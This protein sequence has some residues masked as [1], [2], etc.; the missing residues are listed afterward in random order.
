MWRCAQRDY[1][2]LVH[3]MVE[4]FGWAA[5]CFDEELET[6]EELRAAPPFT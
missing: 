1:S 5:G 4:S 3:W 6:S 2:L